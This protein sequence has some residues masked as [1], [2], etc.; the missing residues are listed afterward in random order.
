[1]NKAVYPVSGLKVGLSAF[2]FLLPD[3]S[4]CNVSQQI[5]TVTD[6]ADGFITV[7]K[8]SKTAAFVTSAVVAA[9]ITDAT[10]GVF[11]D[12]IVARVIS[13]GGKVRDILPLANMVFPSGVKK[14]IS[15]VGTLNFGSIAAAASADLT[16]AVA[17][18][19]VGDSVALGLP[20]APTAGIVFMAFVSATD[21]VTVRA[22]NITGSGVDPASAD[23]RVTVIQA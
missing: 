17:G 12:I 2:T 19:V 11:D 10:N 7:D 3:G 23:Y 22:T 18:A 21:T 16:I 1:M 15:K 14:S 20:A 9:S 8:T 6:N 13:N 4:P 5:V